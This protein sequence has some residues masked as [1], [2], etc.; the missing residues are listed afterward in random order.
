ML[1]LCS[2]SGYGIEQARELDENKHIV[3]TYLDD[4][5]EYNGEI[6][7]KSPVNYDLAGSDSDYEYLGWVGMR[8]F[9]HSHVYCDSPDNPTF[10]YTDQYTYFIES[11]DYTTEVFKIEGTDETLVFCDDLIQC[12]EMASMFGRIE[13]EIIISSATCPKLR[14]S[15]HTYVDDD[16]EF[17]IGSNNNVKFKMSDR[18]Y[19]ILSE[20]GMLYRCLNK[21]G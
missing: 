5:I 4:S 13:N 15:L 10:L 6:Y 14:M 3:F 17:Y 16:G 12:D 19:K 11:F 9:K 21:R 7:Y 20:N 1:S 8:W 18:L 2:C